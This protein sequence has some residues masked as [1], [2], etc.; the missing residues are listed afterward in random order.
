VSTRLPSTPSLFIDAVVC[1]NECSAA[2]AKACATAA[3]VV[4]VRS[5]CC[6]ASVAPFGVDVRAVEC[7]KVRSHEAISVEVRSLR[8]VNAT[9][10]PKNCMACYMLFDTSASIVTVK[11]NIYSARCVQ[12]M[13]VAVQIRT[14]YSALVLHVH[15]IAG[16]THGHPVTHSV[17]QRS[18]TL[19]ATVAICEHCTVLENRKQVT[20]H[21][22]PL[23]T[24]HVDEY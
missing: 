8:M 6:S 15:A 12:Y 17:S 5:L 16:A 21:K 23:A 3:A 22:R 2:I 18:S 14:I 24:K 4:A 7:H 19:S 20:M 13:Y 11:L 9:E 10:Q 1:E